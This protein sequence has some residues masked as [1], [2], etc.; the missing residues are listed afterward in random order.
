[1]HLQRIGR[2]SSVS[3]RT[4]NFIPLIIITIICLDSCN[5][6]KQPIYDTVKIAY[7]NSAMV[8]TVHPLATETGARILHAGGNAVDAAIA[9]HFTLAV[10]Y[11]RAGNIGGGGF[12]VYRSSNGDFSALDF[13]EKA[14]GA[15][16]RD[17]YLDD[18]GEVI[19][20]LSRSGHLA[21][22]VPGS[23]AGMEAAHRKYGRLPFSTL[24]APATE[25]AD[26]GFAITAIEAGRLNKHRRDFLQY[27]DEA[28]PFTKDPPDTLWHAGDTLVQKKLA[29]TLQRIADHGAE[30]FYR[31]ETARHITREMREGGGL[32]DSVD[33][34]SYTTVWREPLD[35][36]YR[37]Y[38]VVSMPPPSSGGVTLGQLLKIA[39]RY[40]LREWGFQDTRTVHLMVEAERRAYADRTYHLADMDYYDVPIDS[41]LD[42]QYLTRQ[43][44]TYSPDS[45]TSSGTVMSTD[46]AV[47]LESYETTHYTVVDPEGNAVAVTTTLNSSYGCKVFVD[48]AG[49]F[50]NN[51][52][53]DFSIKPGVPNQFGLLG[54]EANAIEPGKRMLSSMTPTI[55]EKDGRFCMTIGTPGGSTIITSV[56]QVFLNIAEFE[57]TASEAVRA[58]RFH[59]QWLPDEIVVE[60]NALSPQVRE[61]LRSMGHVF[62]EVKLIGSVEV[63]HRLPDGRLEGAADPRGN[64]HAAGF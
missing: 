49:F 58:R 1:M 42:A 64:D 17:M 34:A 29:E 36:P 14:P 40:P 5:T 59:H 48:D 12:L 10:V 53:D 55:V 3:T 57:M 25:L 28:I 13:R 6:L 38:R 51:E 11:P 2:K 16:Y 61:E 63:I 23:V 41:L 50:L 9:M 62:R 52:M 47:P 31:G 21:A 8:V 60:E 37:N 4:N 43:M 46:F 39:S 32:I 56:F 18:N 44:H 19:P 24:L 54:K 35:I 20:G 26:R 15:A 30:E 22:G 27:N 7:G 33:L 45:A